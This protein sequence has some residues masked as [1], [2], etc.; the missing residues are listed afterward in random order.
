MLHMFLLYRP[1]AFF[2]LLSAPFW[3]LS[4]FLG[5]KY[6][7]MVYW[8]QRPGTRFYL[9][10]LILLVISATFALLFDALAI[11]GV[12]LGANRRLTEEAVCLLR[13]D[14]QKIV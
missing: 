10:T 9:P 14:K 12:L 13:R 6:L 5:S 3:L 4:L 7:W 8:L 1:G 2:S 11:L